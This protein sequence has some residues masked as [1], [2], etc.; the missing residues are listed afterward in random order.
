MGPVDLKS[1]IPFDGP[2]HME[3]PQMYDEMTHMA[4]QFNVYVYP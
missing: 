1:V 4:F 2:G 3:V